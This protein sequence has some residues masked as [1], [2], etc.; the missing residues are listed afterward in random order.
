M[1]PSQSHR[2]PHDEHTPSSIIEPEGEVGR[3]RSRS[4]P[5]KTRLSMDSNDIRYDLNTPRQ[6]GRS[7]SAPKQRKTFQSEFDQDY[8]QI[9]AHRFALQNGMHEENGYAGES[10]KEKTYDLSLELMRDRKRIALH[11]ILDSVK[12]E[13]KKENK[14]PMNKASP[15]KSLNSSNSDGEAHMSHSLDRNLMYQAASPPSSQ[16]HVLGD[17]INERFSF[18]V[19]LSPVQR[20]GPPNPREQIYWT[21]PPH[22]VTWRLSNEDSKLSKAAAIS[23]VCS[24]SQNQDLNNLL[25]RL[26]LCIQRDELKDIAICLKSIQ[27]WITEGSHGSGTQVRLMALCANGLNV[28]LML[29]KFCIKKSFPVGGN[30]S[31]SG[32]A[33][34]SPD[35]SSEIRILMIEALQTLASVVSASASPDG[36]NEIF[37]VMT[38][39]SCYSKNS[40]VT[41]AAL[42]ILAILC[43]RRDAA[44]S[45]A[46]SGCA[47]IL[48]DHFLRI[49]DSDSIPSS[50]DDRRWSAHGKALTLMALASSHR[51]SSLLSRVIERNSVWCKVFVRMMRAA[52]KSKSFGGKPLCME[53]LMVGAKRMSVNPQIAS[54]LCSS[55][56]VQTCCFAVASYLDSHPH[57]S[58]HGLHALIHLSYDEEASLEILSAG[59]CTILCGKFYGVDNASQAFM[60]EAGTHDNMS[61][62]V[63]QVFDQPAHSKDEIPFLQ[64]DVAVLLYRVVGS[65]SE[66]RTSMKENMVMIISSED[67]AKTAEQVSKKLE[68]WGFRSVVGGSSGT[69]D[70]RSCLFYIARCASVVIIVNDGLLLCPSCRAQIE[71]A[72]KVSTP[73]VGIRAGNPECLD[74]SWIEQ[75]VPRESL[76][77]E[78]GG[79]EKK[80]IMQGFAIKCHENASGC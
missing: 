60:C 8:K 17:D 30:S 34:P 75:V 18:S 50:V 69:M 80:D 1:T 58:Q 6:N 72:C 28:F 66:I 20:H 71:F 19:R 36:L 40:E 42:N 21:P 14:K 57:V 51:T 41:F 77:Q 9:L 55:G 35:I 15:R 25:Q 54:K 76:L 29:I 23:P 7:Q 31:K 65:K 70:F 12:I 52:A 56:F 33:L 62:N 24:A 78:Q 47:E 2:S 74:G 46:E 11:Q 64:D 26:E 39:A 4:Q 32:K 16:K 5:G 67:S 49:K 13:K 45:L 10:K 38:E 37:Q 59:L 48:S 53:Q 68:A 61:L 22:H 27:L 44:D 63:S 43:L 79:D 73:M 3:R